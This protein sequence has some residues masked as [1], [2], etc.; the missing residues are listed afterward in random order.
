MF[1]Y[2]VWVE[3]GC[4]S[5]GVLSQIKKNSKRR[6]K[7][8]VRRLIRKQN[9]LLQKKLAASFVRKKKSSFWSD[10]RKLN[11]SSP[12]L[13]PVIDGV[14]GSRSIADVFA[15][16]LND[17]LNTHSPSP[18]FSLQSSIQSSI[19]SLDISRVSFS[20]DDVLEALSHLKSGKSDGDG[21]FAEHLIFASSPLITPLS[22][23]FSS[24]V[25]HGFMPHCFRD[26]VL[27]P[28]PRKNKDDV[29]C[30][31]SYRPIAL[32][33]SLSKTL[34]HLILIK[35][36]TFLHTSPLQFGLTPGSSTTLCTGVVKNIISRYIHSGSSVHGCFLDASR[37]FDLVNHSLLFQKLIDRGL[38]LPVVCFLSSWYSS[39]MMKVCW[40]K[41]LCVFRA[42]DP[43][44]KN[45]LFKS[46]CLSLYGC[47]LWSLSSPSIKLIEVALN[48]LLRKFWCL[49]WISHS[50]IVHCVAQIETIS[51]IVFSRFLS[52]FPLP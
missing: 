19:T 15:S 4:P 5:S 26:F 39:Q 16:K 35:Y 25:H 36:S 3:A 28:V 8:E 31:S 13:P 18:H 42:A 44:V 24:L 11:S 22:D 48:K 41:S 12:S 43:F 34:E 9:D 51:A 2:K 40:D 23:Y 20:E 27:I 21:V 33:S 30:T 29:T 49:P 10:I 14:S 1:W 7:Y 17:T 46:Y 38:P 47:S 6:Y 45:F 37:A 52:L 50:S 32:A